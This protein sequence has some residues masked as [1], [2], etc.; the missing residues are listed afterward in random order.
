[1]I[2]GV[3]LCANPRTDSA[4]SVITTY[5]NINMHLNS[6]Q[7]WFDEIDTNDDNEITE[8]EFVTALCKKIPKKD[9]K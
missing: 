6:L 8:D 3:D 1:M 2:T 5:I 9:V 4:H 7:E